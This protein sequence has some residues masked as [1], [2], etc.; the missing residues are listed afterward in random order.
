MND[1]NEK[2]L[3]LSHLPLKGKY[4]L[5]FFVNKI[6][7]DFFS[8]LSHVMYNRDQNIPDQNISTSILLANPGV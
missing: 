6:L 5:H 4:Q 2:L 7:L 1:M 8:R 3:F